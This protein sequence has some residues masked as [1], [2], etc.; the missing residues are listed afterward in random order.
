MIK[1]LEKWSKGKIAGGALAF[2]SCNCIFFGTVPR[3]FLF[4]IP[5]MKFSTEMVN[6]AIEL[7]CLIS[8]TGAGP[9]VLVIGA[10]TETI[11]YLYSFSFSSLSAKYANCKVTAGVFLCCLTTPLL[12]VLLLFRNTF[13]IQFLRIFQIFLFFRAATQDYFL[14]FEN[15]CIFLKNHVNKRL[16]TQFGQG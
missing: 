16:C 13:S 12:H 10:G 4:S 11:R 1:A 2:T 15:C 7:N 8:T 14:C 9:T 5:L 3:T 6:R